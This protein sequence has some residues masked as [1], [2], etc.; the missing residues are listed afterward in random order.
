MLFFKCLVKSFRHNSVT[1]Q[2]WVNM[3]QYSFAAYNTMRRVLLKQGLGINQMHIGVFIGEFLDDDIYGIRCT[4]TQF[5][6]FFGLVK[7]LLGVS[8][9]AFGIGLLCCLVNTARRSRAITITY[10]WR[11][12]FF[13][14]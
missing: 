14:T 6:Q 1:T 8:I 7:I 3:L 13:I 5:I 9:I 12:G 11:Q 10:K 2:I 4:E